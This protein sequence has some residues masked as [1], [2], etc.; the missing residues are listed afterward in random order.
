MVHL[1]RVVS[2]F[3]VAFESVLVSCHFKGGGLL[4]S[5]SGFC[6]GIVGSGVFWWYGS[7]GVLSGGS[8]L[9]REVSGSGGESGYGVGCCG[10][11]RWVCFLLYPVY[12]GVGRISGIEKRKEKGVRCGVKGVAVLLCELACFFLCFF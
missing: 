10:N 8:G 5:V 11:S 2:G 9:C 7:R 3:Y 6:C 1:L 4:F 12:S